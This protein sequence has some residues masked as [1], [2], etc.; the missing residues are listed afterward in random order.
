MFIGFLRF[1][2]KSK[3]PEL[4]AGHNAWLDAGF[5]RGEIALSGGLQPGLGGA[6]ILTVPDRNRAE[7]VLA[8]DPFVAQGVVA[9]EL[10]EI[11]PGR[12]V[13]ALEGLKG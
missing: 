8:E 9:P 10:V 4:M 6:V 2:D 5:E 13:P 3:A 12:V 1:I 11:T 7:A